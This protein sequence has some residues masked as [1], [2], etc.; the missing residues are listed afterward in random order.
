MSR[1]D[2]VT[3][4]QIQELQQDGKLVVY[5]RGSVYA[6]GTDFQHPGGVKVRCDRH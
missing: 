4:Q 2:S 5:V 6:I 3:R 1:K